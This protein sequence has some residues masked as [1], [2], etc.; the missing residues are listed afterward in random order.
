MQS[1]YLF[2]SDIGL[3]IFSPLTLYHWDKQAIQIRDV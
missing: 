3:N 1:L 2:Q